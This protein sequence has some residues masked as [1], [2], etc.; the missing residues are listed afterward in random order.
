MGKHHGSS[1]E[2]IPL[3]GDRGTSMG[4]LG[5]EVLEEL[6]VPITTQQRDWG[7]QGCQ[8]SMKASLPS[9][10]DQG[11][12]DMEPCDTRDKRSK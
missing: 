12:T 6:L 9:P 1:P 2:L 11:D 4:E 7:S 10:Q 5:W 3:R 8:P